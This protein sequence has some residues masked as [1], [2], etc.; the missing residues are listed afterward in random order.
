VTADC[1]STL[2]PIPQEVR[3]RWDDEMAYWR[4]DE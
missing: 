1:E 4:I 2:V 3:D